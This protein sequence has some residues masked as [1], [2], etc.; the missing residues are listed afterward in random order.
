LS[1]EQLA[2]VER[3]NQAMEEACILA[4]YKSFAHFNAKCPA[5]PIVALKSPRH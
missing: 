2:A 4:G 5:F 3:R 1:V